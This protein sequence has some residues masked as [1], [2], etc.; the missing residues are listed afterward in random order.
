M[1]GDSGSAGCAHARRAAACLEG[2]SWT[3]LEFGGTGPACLEFAVLALVHGLI[4]TGVA[5][6]AVPL[7]ERGV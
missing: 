1:S 4:R 3:H 7:D 6:V 5:D 2:L